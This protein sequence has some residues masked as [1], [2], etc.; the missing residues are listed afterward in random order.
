M[1]PGLAREGSGLPWSVEQG[2]FQVPV[3]AML[4]RGAIKAAVLGAG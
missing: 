3:L 4:A 2:L 1:G